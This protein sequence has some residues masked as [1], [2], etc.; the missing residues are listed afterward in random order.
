ME[1]Y[2]TLRLPLEDDRCRRF[3]A[4]HLR[5]L[6]NV[7]FIGASKC[8][9]TSVTEYLERQPRVHF[10]RRRIHK[11]DRHREVHRFDRNTYPRAFGAIELMD[12]WASSP[13]VTSAADAVIHY[14]PHYLYAPTVPFALRRFFPSEAHTQRLK[15]IVFLRDPT[16]RALSSYWFQNS[17]IFH[18]EEDRGSNSELAELCDAELGQRRAYE[19][20]MAASAAAPDLRKL[21]SNSSSGPLLPEASRRLEAALAQCFGPLLHS[22]RL[23][24]RHVDKGVYADQLE[25]WFACFPRRNFFVTSL[26]RWQADAPGELQRLL[27]FLGMG[28]RV[29]QGGGTGLPSAAALAATG[30]LARLV[31]PNA[32]QEPPPPDLVRRLDGFYRPHLQ[33][34]QR[35]LGADTCPS[36]DLPPAPSPPK[37]TAAD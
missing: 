4:T 23:G 17:H 25:R 15:F 10:V 1:V 2:R 18:P 34:L 29:G 7:F 24:G 26:E 5:C 16:R 9:T 30:P 8:G 28:Q 35:L 19:S 37:T 3:N 11:T 21:N 32:K 13:L 31:R 33:R 36:F 20:C 22:A 27:H 6:P 12:E 14:T